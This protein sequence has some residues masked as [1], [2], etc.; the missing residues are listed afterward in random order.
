MKDVVSGTVVLAF[1]VTAAIMSWFLE[2]GHPSQPSPGFFPFLAALGITA[3]GAT[4]AI[5]G[6]LQGR[7]DIKD[8]SNWNWSWPAVLC[9]VA[10]AIFAQVLELLGFA[11]STFLLM[12]AL[13]MIAGI[14]RWH[15]ALLMGFA[16]AALAEFIFGFLLNM[17]LPPG[18][19]GT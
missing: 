15:T 4:L 13:F 9:L 17:S 16:T 12:S 14:R 19:L 7:Q 8:D 2:L 5:R 3:L 1:G 10:L 18:F 11:L 6:F